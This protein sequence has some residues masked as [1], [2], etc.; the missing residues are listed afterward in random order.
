MSKRHQE[1]LKLVEQDKKYSTEEAV[2]LLKQAGSSKFDETV[3]LVINLKIDVKQSDQLVRGSFSFPKGVG[4]SVRVIAIA[5]EAGAEAAREAG[6]LEAGGDD[7]IK[8]IEDGWF[9]FDVVLAQPSMMKKIGKLGRVLGPKGLMPSPKSGTITED[10]GKA[11]KEFSAGKIE[12]RNDRL[13][14]IQVP[15]GKLSFSENDLCENI[16][17]FYHHINGMRPSSV[18]GVFV[19]SVFI[20]STMGPGIELDL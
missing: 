9:D 10:I 12:F 11:V 19:K 1:N 13:G 18:K 14:S 5:E 4:R 7:L 15:V 17:A 3:E 20:S 16:N 6:A 8:K 2:K